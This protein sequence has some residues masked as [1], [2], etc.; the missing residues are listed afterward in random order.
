M[1]TFYTLKTLVI[2]IIFLIFLFFTQ[3]TFIENY[4]N[5]YSSPIC[6]SR[7]LNRV[8][9]WKNVKDKYGEKV[10]LKIF[11]KTYIFPSDMNSL[12]NDKNTQYILKTKWGGMRK[13]VA[14][15]N[16][17]KKI[18]Q[19]YKNY[20]ISQVYIKNP[21][22]ING[23]KFDIRMLVLVYCGKGILL[24]KKGYCVYT[25]KKFDYKSMDHKQKINQVHTDEDHYDINNL[26]R[27]TDELSKYVNINFDNVSK[28]IAKKLKRIIKSSDKLCCTND[29]G[30]YSIYGLDIEL[31]DNLDPIVIE[32]N[33]RPQI[34]F[35]KNIQ[36]KFEF[37]NEFNRQLE[38]EQFLGGKD[39]IRIDVK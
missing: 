8:S 19:D 29:D 39:W 26:P 13:G 27:T 34:Y 25:N 4:T 3:Y 5:N 28:I 6:G 36:W 37:G 16:S 10:A 1:V 30:K 21:L 32:I 7:N 14:L 31:L 2:I 35:N 22:L 38:N 17:K 33:S 24:Y 12:L 9:I 23:F 20:D 18:K 15:Y 11:P